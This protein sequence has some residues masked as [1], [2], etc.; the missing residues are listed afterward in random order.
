V[1]LTGR[2]KVYSLPFHFATKWS[3]PIPSLFPFY[4]P[5]TPTHPLFALKIEISL[6]GNQNSWEEVL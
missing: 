2:S 5:P 4:L 6:P 1:H 3:D